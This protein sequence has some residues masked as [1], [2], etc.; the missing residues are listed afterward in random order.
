MEWS[1]EMQVIH[2]AALKVSEISDH[3]L[4][5]QQDCFSP[6]TFSVT[7]AGTEQVDSWI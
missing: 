4:K 3:N 1:R 6:A 5:L 2:W 7:G